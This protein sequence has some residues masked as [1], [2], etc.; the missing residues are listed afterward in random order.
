M[1]LSQKK[2]LLSLI[3]LFRGVCAGIGF[4]DGGVLFTLFALSLLWASRE[5]PLSGLFWGGGAVLI[6]HRW[7][8][9][10]HPL[11]WIGIPEVFSLGITILIW[12]L[13]G[14]LGGL[15]TFAW[16]LLGKITFF[17][18]WS[19]RLTKS[20]FFSALALSLIWGLAEVFLAKTPFFWVGVGGSLVSDDRWL[21]GLARWFGEGGL[22]T[23]Q[24]L[25]GWWFWKLVVIFKG[26]MSWLRLFVIG[27]LL[28]FLAP[29][30]LL[31]FYF[32]FQ[33]ILY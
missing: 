33:L 14:L 1:L 13:C 11:A 19:N 24:L 32:S 8:L 25:I 16:C 21:A 29:L 18:N 15:L 31:I 9:A 12:I 7:L 22:A 28:L 17:D 30:F 4:S 2:Y 20:D 3:G 26:R 5:F 6:S 10:L 27:V 23:I